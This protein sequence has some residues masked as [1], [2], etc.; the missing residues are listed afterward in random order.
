MLVGTSIALQLNGN[1]AESRISV[2]KCYSPTLGY[3][4]EIC[5]I[6]GLS[7]RG[8]GLLFLTEHMKT[9]ENISVLFIALYFCKK[10][11]QISNFN[12]MLH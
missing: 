1:V 6:Y 4:L 12:H 11:K 10:Q 3:L 7:Y 8:Y 9:K 5:D 2:L